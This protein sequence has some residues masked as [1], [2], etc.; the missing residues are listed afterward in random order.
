M[1]SVFTKNHINF[2]KYRK[3]S[4]WIIIRNEESKPLLVSSS[5]KK[6]IYNLDHIKSISF[7]IKK[8]IARKSKSQRPNFLIKPRYW[9]TAKAKASRM[10]KG[11]GSLDTHFF[12]INFGSRF[13]SLPL[14][15][16]LTLI[17]LLRSLRVRLPF[18]VAF[19][20]NTNW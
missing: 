8:L 3:P 17:R 20:D 19:F 15:Q 18:N 5:K 10:G 1:K 7:Y 4:P 6:V 9:L 16:Q 13:I 2:N 12:L 11:K 14:L